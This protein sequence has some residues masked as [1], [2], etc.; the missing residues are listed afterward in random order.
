MERT[1]LYL[2]YSPILR[3]FKIGISNISNER[4]SSHRRRGWIIMK[5][6]ILPNRSIAKD[7]EKEVLKY[8]REK[9][10]GEYL[11][12]E[13]LPQHGYTEC[14]N[15]NLMSSKSVVNLINREIKK[16]SLEG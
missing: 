7:V 5:Y 3:A 9:M 14:F 2:I 8:L 4:Y 12:K 6:W 15:S 16:R 13:D 10:P 1:I 11:K